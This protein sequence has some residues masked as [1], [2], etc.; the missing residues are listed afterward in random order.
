MTL[1]CEKQW[2]MQKDIEYNADTDLNAL[3]PSRCGHTQS[4]P[5]DGP[6]DKVKNW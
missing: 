3:T 6:K 5:M 2:L 1:S 4:W